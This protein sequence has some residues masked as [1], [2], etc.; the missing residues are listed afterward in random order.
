MF[1]RLHQSYNVLNSWNT[2]Y[3]TLITQTKSRPK[4]GKQVDN[5]AGRQATITRT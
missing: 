4:T 2:P 3:Q 1:V 5:Q